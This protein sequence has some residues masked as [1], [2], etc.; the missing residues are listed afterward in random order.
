MSA[1]QTFRSGKRND[2]IDLRVVQ[3]EAS[4]FVGLDDRRASLGACF[5]FCGGSQLQFHSSKN[6]FFDRESLV[7]RFL[8]QGAVEGIG[9]VNGRSH[10]IILPY[11][12]LAHNDGRPDAGGKPM[13]RKLGEWTN[14]R[15]RNRGGACQDGAKKMIASELVRFEAIY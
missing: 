1:I 15:P 4:R 12:W 10:F 3:I 14:P 5:C 13:M 8:L 11:L 9:D 7:S 2:L 6:Q